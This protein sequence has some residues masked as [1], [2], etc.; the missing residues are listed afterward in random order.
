MEE[1]VLPSVRDK[2]ESYHR[3]GKWKIFNPDRE[4]DVSDDLFSIYEVYLQ[5]VRAAFRALDVK[6]QLQERPVKNTNDIGEIHSLAAAMLLDAKIICSNDYDIREVIEDTPILV[7]NQDDSVLLEH[8][9]LLDFCHW[10]VK[11]DVESR[12]SVRKFVKV[13]IP[14]R[15]NEFDL[16][17]L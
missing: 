3:N 9:T 1:L 14:E 5:E 12:K 2:V 7:N 8:D 4:E 6:K 17:Y 10:V 16:K 15:L 13:I 11:F